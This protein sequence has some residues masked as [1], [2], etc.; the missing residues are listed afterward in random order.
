MPLLK[1][2]LGGEGDD[3]VPT[4][5]IPNTRCIK[6]EIPLYKSIMLQ[7]PATKMI[8]VLQLGACYA[9]VS[10]GLVPQFSTSDRQAGVA[11]N[12][13]NWCLADGR[14]DLNRNTDDLGCAVSRPSSGAPGIYKHHN[15]FLPNP[16]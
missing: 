16:G 2:A 1:W 10:C 9:K 12:S 11:V 14:F 3:R 7:M 8:V 13:A 4:P 15:R 6:G 5:L